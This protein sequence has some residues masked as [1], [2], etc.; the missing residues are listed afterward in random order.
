MYEKEA[1]DG[2]LGVGVFLNSLS[3]H[4][5]SGQRDKE[6]DL[7]IESTQERQTG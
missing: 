1:V 2:S 6:A 7:K 4:E 3:M 5:G